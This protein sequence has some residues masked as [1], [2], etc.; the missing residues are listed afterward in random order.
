MIIVIANQKGG[1]GKT[2]TAI[3]LA[4]SLSILGKGKN[5]KKVLLIDIDPQGN[6]SS[7]IGIN[8]NEVINSMYEVIT[9]K[10]SIKDAITKTEYENLDVL[11]A[12]IKL[13]NA[14]IELASVF[15]RETL[16]KEAIEEAN[17][18]YDYIIIDCNPSLGLLTVNALTSSEQVIIPLEPAEFSLD[19]IEQLLSL[20]KLVKKKLNSTL[21]IMG[22]LLTRVPQTTNLAKNFSMQL[23]QMFGNKFFKTNIHHNIALPESQTKHVPIMIYDAKSKGAEQYIEF[24]KEVLKYVG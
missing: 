2:T 17:L 20:I 19:G 24:S 5:R 23:S 3:N 4:Y 6:A 1:V 8:K 21:N 7:G 12:N 9:G 14:D 18:D 22:V 15:G 10:I 16:L 13:A 11:P